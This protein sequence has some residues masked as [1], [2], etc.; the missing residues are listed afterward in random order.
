MLA[1]AG[2]L[3]GLLTALLYSRLLVDFMAWLWPDKSLRSLLRPHASPSS[4]GYGVL[5][6]VLAAAVTVWWVTRSLSKIAPRALLSGQTT[7]ENASLKRSW[8]LPI[9]TISAALAAAALL[10]SG[11]FVQGQEE[12]AGTFFGSGMLLLTAGLCCVRL[13]M[14]GDRGGWRAWRA[15]ACATRPGTRRGACWRSGCWRRRCS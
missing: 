5:G 6:A 11:F 15:S 3:L 13:W 12:W 9:V 7:E 1:L 14:R 2:A 8:W 4:M 10:V